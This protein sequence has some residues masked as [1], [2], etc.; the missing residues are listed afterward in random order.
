MRSKERPPFGGRFCARADPSWIKPCKERIFPTTEAGYILWNKKGGETLFPVYENEREKKLMVKKSFMI[1]V[2]LFSLVACSKINIPPTAPPLITFTPYADG[3]QTAQAGPSVTPTSLFSTFPTAVLPTGTAAPIESTVLPTTSGETPGNFSPV[4][5]A[6]NFGQ[7][8]SYL[9]LGAVSRDAWL[10]PEESVSRFVGEATYRFHTMNA[11]NKYFLRG[12]A[13]EF[14]PTCKAYWVGM[15]TD[16][17]EEG[18]VA[19]LDGWNVTKYAVLELSSAQ[20]TFYRQAVL[21]WLRSQGMPNPPAGDV[22]IFRVDLE[23]DGVDEVL[24]SATHLDE[25]QHTTQA[26]DYSIVLMRKLIGNDVVTTLVTGDMYDSQYPQITNPA[27]YSLANFIDL[28]Q[29]G[30]MEVV[31]DATRWEGGGAFVYQVNGQTIQQVLGTIC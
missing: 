28:D 30:V 2:L 13:P 24:V 8:T 1:F 3:T 12:R 26:G 14:S 4:L 23:D 20:D 16:P 6:G 11:L 29:D 18:L 25:S 21:D 19:T 17:G 7:G 15:D 10:S 27:A 9:L 5:Y 31:V 22:R